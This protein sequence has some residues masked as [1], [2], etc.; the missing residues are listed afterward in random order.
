MPNQEYIPS[1]Q[2]IDP[3]KYKMYADPVGRE[4]MIMSLY[5]PTD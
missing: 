3:Q 2:F 5:S 4:N 1:P